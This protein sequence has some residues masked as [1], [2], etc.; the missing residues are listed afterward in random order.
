M[1]SVGSSAGGFGTGLIE[2]E[3]HVCVHNSLYKKSKKSGIIGFVVNSLAGPLFEHVLQTDCNE[4][5]V[6]WGSKVESEDISISEVSDVENI[7]NMVAEKTSYV[8]FNAFETDNM[9]D[10]VTSRKI[11]TKTYVLEPPP[12]TPFFKNLS[13]NDT[14]LVFLESKFVGSNWLLSAKSSVLERCSFEPVRS[15]TLDIELAVVPEKTNGNKL[16]SIKKN[17]YRING[18]T[19]DYLGC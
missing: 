15:F 5:K 6:S 19:S 13:D 17:F 7:N 3:F 9:V 12:K 14:E 10:N 11:Q 2:L 18:V 1:K 4:R 8:N 16:I